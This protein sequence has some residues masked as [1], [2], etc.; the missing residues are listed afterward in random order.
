MSEDKSNEL[1]KK[2]LAPV[3]RI[4]ITLNWARKIHAPIDLEDRPDGSIS[5]FT[6]SLVSVLFVGLSTIG[7]F[8][9]FR[10]NLLD[11]RQPLGNESTF[12]L[13]EHLIY[14]FRHT[15]EQVLNWSI[16]SS[17]FVLLISTVWSFGFLVFVTTIMSFQASSSGNRVA[18]VKTF[19]YQLLPASFAFFVIGVVC[20]IIGITL[21][22]I[23]LDSFSYKYH[24]YLVFAFLASTISVSFAMC[25]FGTRKRSPIFKKN[26]A[27][28]NYLYLLFVLGSVGITM[29]SALWAEKLYP[30]ELDVAVSSHCGPDQ[31]CLIFI[32]SKNIGKAVLTDSIRVQM[33][34][35]PFDSTKKASPG[36]P[37]SH[38][39]RI[40]LAP[41]G[42]G[43]ELILIN[44]AEQGAYVE[45]VTLD[46]PPLPGKKLSFMVTHITG[47]TTVHLPD[48]GDIDNVQ[49]VPVRFKGVSQGLL[50][51]ASDNCS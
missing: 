5:A 40:W 10:F 37:I 30:A 28:K 14:V 7:L 12:A 17:M 31:R 19:I 38:R 32:R 13:T 24:D 33:S 39:A 9:F 1:A 50:N 23:K 16:D 41:S 11:M 47:G 20:M 43:D 35:V 26:I 29:Q 48:E 49:G 4:A 34:L 45:K 36:L 3:F 15:T 22:T 44:G 27:R 51:M 18:Q 2:L 8:W 25:I 46:C 6:S 42:E 21:S